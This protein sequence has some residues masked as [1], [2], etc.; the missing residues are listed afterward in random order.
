[1]RQLLA[2]I[3][4]IELVNSQKLNKNVWSP[5]GSRSEVPGWNY[6]MCVVCD[7]QLSPKLSADVLKTCTVAADP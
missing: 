4:N 1:M 6:A 7:T 2:I 5:N 3:L